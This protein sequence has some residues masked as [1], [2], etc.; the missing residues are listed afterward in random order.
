M[1]TFRGRPGTLDRVAKDCRAS[2]TAGPARVGVRPKPLAPG[3][4]VRAAQCATCIY[5]PGSPQGLRMLEDKTRGHGR[6]GAMP[7]VGREEHGGR[8]QDYTTSDGETPAEWANTD[9]LCHQ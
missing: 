4:V 2:D 5:R 3:L 7:A 8:H 6:R 1:A 9:E